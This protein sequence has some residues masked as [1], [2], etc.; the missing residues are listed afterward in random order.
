MTNSV[1]FSLIAVVAALAALAGCETPGRLAKNV[2][3]DWSGTPVRFDKK[4][5]VNGE[6]TP[7][8]SFVRASNRAGGEMTLSARLSVMMPVNAPI[9]SIGTTAVSATAAGLATVRG[10]WEADGDDDIDLAFDL[11]T[12]VINMDPEVEFELA[13]VW[14]SGDAPTQR[15]VSEAVKKSFVKQMR[16]AMTSALHE[17]DDIDDIKFIDKG[18][19]MT[20]KFADVRQTLNR[21]YN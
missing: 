10:T 2:E 9:D 5:P 13:N 8:F 15:T 16:D 12:L 17:M 7:V 19:K 11:S 6:F 21:V 1:R 18:T 14:A 20:C 3:G 4:I